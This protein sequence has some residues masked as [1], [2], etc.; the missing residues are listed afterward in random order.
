MSDEWYKSKY[1]EYKARKRREANNASHRKRYRKKC[2]EM[3][4]AFYGQN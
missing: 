3:W 4:K 1:M 2:E